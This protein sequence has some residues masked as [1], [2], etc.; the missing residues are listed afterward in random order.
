[1]V[2]FENYSLR[3]N[4]KFN[5]LYAGLKRHISSGETDKARETLVSAVSLIDRLEKPKEGKDTAPYI[6]TKLTAYKVLIDLFVKL[7]S[8][9]NPVVQNYEE[10][11]I[12]KILDSLNKR[13]GEEL[14]CRALV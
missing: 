10:E 2:R 9:V 1:M 11:K 8:F 3:F 6:L 5:E 13:A 4:T 14:K 12:K 7:N